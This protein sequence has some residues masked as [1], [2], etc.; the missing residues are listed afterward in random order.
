ML[1]EQG[2]WNRDLYLTAYPYRVTQCMHLRLSRIRTAHA[3]LAWSL[4]QLL[5]LSLISICY[6]TFFGWQ[7]IDKLGYT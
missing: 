4:T 2:R 7:W 3:R 1:Y 5:G 6:S